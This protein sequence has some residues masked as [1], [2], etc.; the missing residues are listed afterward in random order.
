MS[1]RRPDRTTRAAIYVPVGV[2]GE[3]QK[4]QAAI[5][6]QCALHRGWTVLEYRERT[7]RAKTRPVFSQ[8]MAAAK[9]RRFGT[10]VVLSLD[11]LARSIPELLATLTSLKSYGVQFF[12]LDDR[13]NLG[14]D[15]PDAGTFL[16]ALRVLV[17]TETRMNIRNVREGVARAQRQGV[18]CGRPARSFPRAEARQLRQEGLSIPAIA[19]RIGVPATTV[20]RALRADQSSETNS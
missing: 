3:D 4:S 7:A 18:H 12:S 15:N 8:M 9:R 2:P 20:A 16:Q 19:A 1:S 5:L 17:Q 11:R 10:L 13:I 14:E 6:R